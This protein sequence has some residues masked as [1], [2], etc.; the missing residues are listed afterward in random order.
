MPTPVK[1]DCFALDLGKGYH[2]F[3]THVMK[4]V[5][6]LT[7]PDVTNTV[8]GDIAQITSGNGYT[9][10]G[11]TAALTSWSQT[12][13]AAKLVLADPAVWTATGGAMD[14]FRYA[15]LYNSTTTNGP[16][17]QYW[18]YGGTITLLEGESFLADLSAADGVLVV[19]G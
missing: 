14:S 7:A 18:D 17:V 13:G 9:V 19:G 4:V 10:D 15:T 5:L 12:S 6:S 8:L 16:L 3:T 1:F 2:N 11:N